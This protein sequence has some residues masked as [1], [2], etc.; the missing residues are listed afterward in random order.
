LHYVS[1]VRKGLKFKKAK[2]MRNS[3]NKSSVQ[4]VKNPLR[5]I[6]QQLCMPVM[7][8]KEEFLQTLQTSN[9]ANVTMICA[10][11]ALSKMIRNLKNKNFQPKI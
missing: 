4:L 1:I 7:N 8:V 3:N 11:H 6:T 10:E 5:N 2:I 9:V